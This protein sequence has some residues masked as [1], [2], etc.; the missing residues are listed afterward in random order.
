MANNLSFDATAFLVLSVK[1]RVELCKRMAERAQELADTAGPTNRA[2]YLDIAK[3]WRQ[4]AA[5]IE[6]VGSVETSE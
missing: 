1:E 5:E 3:G 2:S 6:R 4:L